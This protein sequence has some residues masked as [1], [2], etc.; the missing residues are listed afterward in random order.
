MVAKT[1]HPK[2]DEVAKKWVL[3][4]AEGQTLGRMATRI[5]R[6]LLGKDKPQFTPGVDTGDYVVVINA[7][8]TG[9]TGRKLDEKVYFRHSL[10]PGGVKAVS[11]REQL[12]RHPERV[13]QS[14]VWG[15]LPHNRYGR[16]LLRKLK[17]YAGADHP[18]AA[19][20]P[21]AAGK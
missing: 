14:A 7:A 3:I 8:K 15:M 2:P 10:Y 5:A 4:D 17:V 6:S 9:V 1:Y 21:R 20:S 13:I 19:Q 12:A 16:K 18:H 11:L